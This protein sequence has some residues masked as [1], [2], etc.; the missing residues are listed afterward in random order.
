MTNYEV[1]GPSYRE[2]IDTAVWGVTRRLQIKSSEAEAIKLRDI[3]R[4]IYCAASNANAI[5]EDSD[6]AKA[7][8]LACCREGD[9]TIH[10][11]LAGVDIATAMRLHLQNQ[12][13]AIL[14][15]VIGDLF[16]D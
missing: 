13:S 6:F 11:R 10:T 7:I 4:T 16:N 12:V 1:P 5:A 15:E 3:I 8:F 2:L 9:V 14:V